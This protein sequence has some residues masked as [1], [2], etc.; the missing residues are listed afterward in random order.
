MRE[1]DEDE[2]KIRKR[3]E[4]DTDDKRRKARSEERQKEE[5]KRWRGI[6]ESLYLM[7]YYKPSFVWQCGLEG[8]TLSVCLSL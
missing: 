6:K 2:K 5:T 4:R 8:N 7:F 1:R 3:G